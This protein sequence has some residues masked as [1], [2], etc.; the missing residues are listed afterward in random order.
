MWS[1]DHVSN[2]QNPSAE[3][4]CIRWRASRE[5]ESEGARH[6]HGQGVEKRV[7]AVTFCL[8]PA[9][10]NGLTPYQADH[11][12]DNGQEDGRRRHVTREFREKSREHG[13]DGHKQPL[14][15]CVQ[16]VQLAADKVRQ[17]T[18]FDTLTGGWCF[19]LQI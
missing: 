14:R 6:R 18:V 16:A 12:D 8:K 3:Y 4:D 5:H 13:S 19:W 15:Q 9:S 7:N 1:A 10:C 2:S 11:R 17:S